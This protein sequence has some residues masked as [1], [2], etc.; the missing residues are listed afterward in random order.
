MPGCFDPVLRQAL[1]GYGQPR[2]AV[3]HLNTSGGNSILV[4]MA[5]AT[6][7]GMTVIGQEDSLSK[8]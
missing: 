8:G 6:I 1:K 7:A 4:G 5:D 2:N 3:G